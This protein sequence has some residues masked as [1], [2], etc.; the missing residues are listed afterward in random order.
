MRT[1]FRS[2]S[3]RLNSADPS[4]LKEIAELTKR[5]KEIRKEKNKITAKMS[6]DRKLAYIHN[7]ESMLHDAKARIEVL[8]TEL[9]ATSHDPTALKLTDSSQSTGFNLV[10]DED[11]EGNCSALDDLPPFDSDHE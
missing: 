1:M 8:E 11:D 6:R 7:L 3:M 9:T 2:S 10:K 5:Q 4:C